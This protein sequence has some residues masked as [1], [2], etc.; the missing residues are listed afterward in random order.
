VCGVL[1]DADRSLL[2]K[3]SV[4][5]H[6]V[7]RYKVA[8]DTEYI[9]L[10]ASEDRKGIHFH[11]DVMKADYFHNVRHEP[12]AVGKKQI[13]EVASLVEGCSLSAH[14]IA[15]FQTSKD[16]VRRELWEPLEGTIIDDGALKA[17]FRFLGSEFRIE[18]APID[19]VR[20]F[21]L[22][23]TG[24]GAELSVPMKSTINPDYVAEAFGL[25]NG[26]FN[27]IVLNRSIHGEHEDGE[28][29][30]AEGSAIH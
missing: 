28:S 19:Y 8:G 4:L 23:D 1:E 22:T 27:V 17:R 16:L 3:L 2:A 25:V 14:V 10:Y 24:L 6:K 26:A 20:I 13:D 15:R 11:I 21:V 5:N 7:A 29:H 9:E 12:V 30:E 18:D